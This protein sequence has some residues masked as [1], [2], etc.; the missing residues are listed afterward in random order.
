MNGCEVLRNLVTLGIARN[1]SGYIKIIDEGL[2]L[3]H[4]ANLHPWMKSKYIK[5]S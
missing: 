3:K 2:I 5:Q 4:M 1:S